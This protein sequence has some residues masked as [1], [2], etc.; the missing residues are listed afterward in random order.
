MQPVVTVED[1]NPDEGIAATVFSADATLYVKWLEDLSS[2][3]DL[4]FAAVSVAY[5][6]NAVPAT[7]VFGE[8]FPAAERASVKVEYRPAEARSAEWAAEAPVNV[9]TYDVRFVYNGTDQYAPFTKNYPAGI[10]ITKAT[11]QQTGLTPAMAEVEPGTK[12]SDI[13]LTNGVVTLPATAASV[14]G[15]WSWVDAEGVVNET[16]T[17]QAVFMPIDTANYQPLYVDVALTVKASGSDEPGGEDPDNP[18]NPDQPGGS[19]KPDQPGTDPDQPGGSGEPVNPDNPDGDQPG[20]SDGDGTTDG[21]GD[22]AGTGD[23]DDANAG[24]AETDDNG[25]DK[26]GL[27]KLSDTGDPA[28]ALFAGIG[29]VLVAALVAAAVALRKMTRKN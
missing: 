10:V 2:D 6:G 8:A 26:D 3:A 9:G 1:A 19:N 18:D 22:G 17:Y 21:T 12:L 13:A 7:P 11:L 16:G 15:A 25:S 20:T 23:G 24:D 4:S 28:I 27:A 5:T 14:E 29:A